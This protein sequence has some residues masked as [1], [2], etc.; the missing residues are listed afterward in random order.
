MNDL[1]QVSALKDPTFWGTWKK[2][3]H[4]WDDLRD[5]RCWEK[6]QMG[7]SKAQQSSV[8]CEVGEEGLF[9]TDFETLL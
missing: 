3:I 9:Y 4:W 2:P 6:H 8:G 1:D 5:L 7:T